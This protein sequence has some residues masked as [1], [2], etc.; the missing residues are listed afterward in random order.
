MIGQVEVLVLV[1]D[2][3][4]VAESV[5]DGLGVTVVRCGSSAEALP[6]ERFEG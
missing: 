1:V 3:G 5:L 4:R 6:S 2:D